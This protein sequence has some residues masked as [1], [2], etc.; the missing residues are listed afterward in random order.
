MLDCPKCFSKW[1]CPCKNCDIKGKSKWSYTSD[2]NGWA[3]ECGF[4]AEGGYW[5]DR[6]VDILMKSTGTSSLSEAV[7]VSDTRVRDKNAKN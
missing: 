7:R 4:E 1:I 5:L 2:G 3:C 6:E